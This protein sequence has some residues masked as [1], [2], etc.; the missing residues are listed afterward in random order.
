MHLANSGAGKAP[1]LSSI[2]W[3]DRPFLPLL[4]AAEL[5]GVSPASLYRLETEGKLSFTRIN[6]RTLVVVETIV[7]LID[8]TEGWAPSTRGSAARAKRTERARARWN[9]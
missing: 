7:A 8:N 3:R 1:K 9:P 5:L 2:P 6:G 4:S